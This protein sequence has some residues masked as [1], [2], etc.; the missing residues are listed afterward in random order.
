MTDVLDQFDTA[1]GTLCITDT[2]GVLVY[3]NRSVEDRVGYSVSQVIDK[4]PGDLWGGNMDRAY[5]ETMWRTIKQGEP[6]VGSIKTIRK[7]GQS[8]EDRVHIAPVLA[9]G[10]P[11]YYLEIHPARPDDRFSDTFVKRMRQ[12]ETVSLAHVYEWISGVSAHGFTSGALVSQLEN[13]LIEPRQLEYAPRRSD[14][15]LVRASQKTPAAFASLYTKYY[16]DVQQYFARRVGTGQEAHDLAQEAFVRAFSH[17]HRF[18][19]RN[20]S[21][22]TYMLRIAHN[23]LVNY[24]RQ[25]KPTQ[26]IDECVG[27][28][29]K[30]TFTF[31]DEVTRALKCLTRIET[32]IVTMKYLEGYR[33]KEIAVELQKTDNA[34]KLHLSRARKKMRAFLA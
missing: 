9:N 15:A 25:Q 24:Y 28:Y 20:A 23:L 17:I 33:V 32:V 2:S 21:Y 16:D 1:R 7:Q 5:Y 3:T 29:Q 34:V 18:E 31:Q 26:S 14:F 22:K 13:G 30:N 19:M 8:F 12:Q 10:K 4:K 6:F 11:C 27:D